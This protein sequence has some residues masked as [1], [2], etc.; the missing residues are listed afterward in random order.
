MRKNLKTQFLTLLLVLSLGGLTGLEP[1]LHNHDLELYD[2][3]ED[4]ISCGWTQI[5]IDQAPLQAVAVQ[6]SYK[7]LS[8]KTQ[9][10]TPPA[11]LISPSRSR[12]PPVLS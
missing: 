10:T 6:N 3:H 11:S 7:E 2:E 5:S 12:A 8:D 4:C 1:V 9:K